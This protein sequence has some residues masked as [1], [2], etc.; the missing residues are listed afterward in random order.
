MTC[1]WE[2]IASAI[3]DGTLAPASAAQEETT[4]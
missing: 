3:L 2:K 4:E 1:R